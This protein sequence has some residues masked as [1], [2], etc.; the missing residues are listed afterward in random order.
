MAAS[1]LDNA[2]RDESS[3]AA[4]EAGPLDGGDHGVDVLVGERRLLGQ[5]PA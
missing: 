1:T 4:G 5:S 2:E 3:D